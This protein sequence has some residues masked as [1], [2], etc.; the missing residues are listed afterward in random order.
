[1]VWIVSSLREDKKTGV[2]D[3][4]PQNPYAELLFSGCFKK[5]SEDDG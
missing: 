5:W 1:M 4:V 3:T 2:F